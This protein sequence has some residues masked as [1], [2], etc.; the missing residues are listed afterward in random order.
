MLISGITIRRGET[1]MAN[2][3]YDELN[4]GNGKLMNVFMNFASQFK[5]NPESIVQ[6]LMNSGM[7]SQEDFN[8]YSKMAEDAG[9]K[10]R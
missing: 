2:K 10:R 8:K 6:L 1:E 7:M 9:L 3:L 4:Q 5:G